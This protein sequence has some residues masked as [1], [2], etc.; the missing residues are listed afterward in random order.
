MHIKYLQKYLGYLLS[1]Q[2]PL[3]ITGAMTL[4]RS[5]LSFWTTP[6][7]SQCPFETS[8]FPALQNTFCSSREQK[9]AAIS[10][11]STPTLRH[12]G[13]PYYSFQ[14]TKPYL[15]T[16]TQLVNFLVL[17]ETPLKS[18]QEKAGITGVRITLGSDTCGRVSGSDRKLPAYHLGCSVE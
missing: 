10:S 11:L 15:L 16:N 4:S 7:S 17:E 8:Q 3:G 1:V 2:Y 5:W 13:G 9:R 18:T 12:P 14:A 6:L